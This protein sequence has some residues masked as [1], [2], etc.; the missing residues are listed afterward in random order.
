MIREK[1]TRATDAGYGEKAT[2]GPAMWDKGRQRYEEK[3][4]RAGDGGFRGKRTQ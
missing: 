3:A 1:A 4:T 2:H